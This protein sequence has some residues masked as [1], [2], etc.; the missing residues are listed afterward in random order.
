MVFIPGIGVH[1]LGANRW[2]NFHY[3][4]LQPAEFVKLALAIYLAAWFSQKEKGRFTAFAL[5]IG[6][7][8]FLVMIQ[9][10]MGTACIIPPCDK[11]L[12]FSVFVESI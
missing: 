7:V 12:N 1:I 8:F 6:L 11:L 4:V 9:P 10:D 3:F 2:L 5:L